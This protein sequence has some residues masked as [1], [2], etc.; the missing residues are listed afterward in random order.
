MQR[1]LYPIQDE[2]P[3]LTDKV[4][5]IP[6]QDEQPALAST[7]CF[8]EVWGACSG[9]C[10]PGGRTATTGCSSHA[11]GT[12]SVGYSFSV[13]A[14]FVSSGGPLGG[15]VPLGAKTQTQTSQHWL[16]FTGHWNS[17]HWLFLPRLSLCVLKSAIL[18]ERGV[19]TGCSLSCWRETAS[20]QLGESGPG[21]PGQGRATS[22]VRLVTVMFLYPL[23]TSI[24]TTQYYQI[25]LSFSIMFL[26]VG[27]KVTHTCTC[28]T[29]HTVMF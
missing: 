21:F 1:V 4:G 3:E 27:H 20:A 25:M 18:P 24:Y 12:A 17:Q 15:A 22:Y 29:N 11:T 26:L 5:A 23:L 2:Q 16:F 9:F 10:T 28:I 19:S 14:V 8:P 13:L 7:G 6:V